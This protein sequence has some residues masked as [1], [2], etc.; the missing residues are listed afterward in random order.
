MLR[1]AVTV[2]TATVGVVSLATAAF[3]YYALT[4]TQATATYTVPSLAAAAS[5]LASATD[6]T[7][8]AVSWTA[9]AAQLPGASYVV[10]NTTD[11][12]TVCTVVTTSCTDTA[13]LP[14][15]VN[16]LPI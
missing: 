6:P 13:A 16:A 12:H 14:G 15:T 2:A 5:P 1:R 10:T 3:A 8:V 7:T 9:P 11:D 4:S